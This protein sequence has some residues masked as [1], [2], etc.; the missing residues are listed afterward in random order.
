MIEIIIETKSRSKRVFK[1]EDDELDSY[2]EEV[3][4]AFK[5]GKPLCIG[6]VI[7][8]TLNVTLVEFQSED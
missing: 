7:F 8:N 5:G 6:G 3:L 4:K 2:T 1:V